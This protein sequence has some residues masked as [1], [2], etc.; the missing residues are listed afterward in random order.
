MKSVLTKNTR[1]ESEVL[2][3]AV[4]LA[5][6]N[7][8]RDMDKTLLPTKIP[9]IP[10]ILKKQ[11]L[12]EECYRIFCNSNGIFLES[13]SLL[14]FVYGI[15]E[16][17]RRFLGVHDF[18]FWNDQVFE[19]K[20]SIAV[21]DQYEVTSAPFRV[22][23]RGWFVNDEVLI[24]KWSVMRD[25]VEP[26]RMVFEAL[27]R[28]GGNM[29]IPGTDRN[30][31]KY[32][33]LASDMGLFLTHHHAEPMGAEMFARAYPKLTPSYEEH[34]ELFQELWREALLNQNGYRV[35]WNL[36]FRG[37][38]DCPFWEH[39]PRYQTDEARGTLMSQLI[40]I[41][42]DMVKESNPDAICCTNL[43]G[44]TMEL[45]QKGFLKLPK[46][47]IHIW[48]DN[49]FGKMVSRRQ[50][51]HNPRIPALPKKNMGGRH[52]IYYHASFYDLQAAN[53][54]TMLP[55]SPEFV[56]GEL[57]EVLEHGADDY[58]IIN[59]SNV[60]P[61]VFYLTMIAQMWKDGAVAD[62]WADDYVRKY[63]GQDHEDLVRQCFMEFSR[64]AIKCG[65]N[66]DDHA[67][68]QFLN[69]I[70][71]ILMTQF[72]KDKNNRA[73]ELLWTGAKERLKE[74]VAWFHGLCE[75]AAESYEEYLNLCTKTSLMLNGDSR[76]LFCDSLLLQV[77]LLYE[78]CK[79]SDLVCESLNYGFQNDYKRA[80]YYAGCACEQYRMADRFM[81]EREH[82]K[83]NG[84]YENEC[85]T[86][87]KQ[88]AWVAETLMGYFRVLGDGPHFYQWQR[89]FFNSEADRRVML[90]LNMENH[91][92]HQE[93]FLLM[94]EQWEDKDCQQISK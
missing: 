94:K 47:V 59:C 12:K 39:D 66:E 51:N 57:N 82:G 2:D 70:P 87:V 81:R 30:S 76:R 13:G 15:Y 44:E 67:G 49:G 4:V 34:K 61:H 54:I 7:L 31:R 27:L 72:M 89:E 9:G 83:W 75:P 56:C 19:K 53:H 16:I 10:I 60:K 58:W 50:E 24:D 11:E 90:I 20:E 71:R 91:L 65:P 46:D 64:H 18:W 33:T 21:P 25:K 74:Q 6:E 3:K 14:G 28:C 38:G 23:L 79:A 40:T 85:L 26:W 88:S 35:I 93:L 62:G 73:C 86:D 52:G 37:Q 8:K 80:F 36:G 63:Y 1:I 68:E 22:K 5:L 69:H 92:T 29:V 43:Y 78:C 41:Q 77:R 84:F 45:Y 42:Y 17:S 32:R 55:N 48:A